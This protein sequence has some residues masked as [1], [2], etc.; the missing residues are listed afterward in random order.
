[1]KVETQGELLH[2]L[3]RRNRLTL[4][5]AARKLGT[6][7]AALSR[8]ERDERAIPHPILVRAVQ[9]YR[10]RPDELLVGWD[11]DTPGYLN[12]RRLAHGAVARS[13]A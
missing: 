1:M 4:R 8:Y 11:S 9:V 3:R 7:D 10:V 13:A 5:E 6:S 12:G 2:R